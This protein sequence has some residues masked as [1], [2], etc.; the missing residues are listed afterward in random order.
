MVERLA[1]IRASVAGEVANARG[2]DAARAA[3]QRLFEGFALRRIEPGLRVPGELAWTDG[4]G[5]ILEPQVLD[6]V[7]LRGDAIVGADNHAV[8]V[9]T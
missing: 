4:G 7:V 2:A 1:A 3:I 5:F 8:G 9:V 6:G